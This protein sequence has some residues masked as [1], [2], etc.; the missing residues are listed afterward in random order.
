MRSQ[1]KTQRQPVAP[2]QRISLDE[3]RRSFELGAQM[4]GVI[5]PTAPRAAA[6]SAA[7]A[8]VAASEPVPTAWEEIQRLAAQKAQRDGI[9]MEAAIA[10][11]VLENPRLYDL[12]Q[13]Q[14]RQR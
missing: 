3:L 7:P 12:Y 8:P 11:V 1:L 5:L 14:Q 9:T 2:A 4:A 13:R 6:R 10:A